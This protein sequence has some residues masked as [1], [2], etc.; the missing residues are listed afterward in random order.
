MTSVHGPL[1]STVAGQA[2]ITTTA[3]LALNAAVEAKRVG[4]QGRVA[5]L[6]PVATEDPRGDVGLAGPLGRP[7]LPVLAPLLE[8]GLETA[9]NTVHPRS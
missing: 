3:I 8:R 7:F 2:D 6:E 1:E 9:Q 4:E 5:P